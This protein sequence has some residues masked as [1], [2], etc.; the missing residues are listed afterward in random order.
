[1]TMQ[2]KI[3][4]LKNTKNG[5]VR[6]TILS[7]Q[8]TLHLDLKQ[9]L[10][11][12]DNAT[13]KTITEPLTGIE[14]WGLWIAAVGGLIGILAKNQNLSLEEIILLDKVQKKKELTKEEAKHLKSKNLIEGRRPNYFI[15][16]NV[17]QKTGQK[18]TYAKNK[19]FDKQYYLDLIVKSIKQHKSL[20]RSDIDDLLWKK[21][22]D[23]M[24][25]KQ[26]KSKIGNL[27]TELRKKEKIINKGIYSKPQWHLK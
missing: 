22:P 5:I 6:D 25:D 1:M 12:P 9:E 14:Y 4:I 13:V 21:L 16:K 17:A 10:F 20:T 27:I 8:D 15:G 3:I 23:Y 26:K 19:A 2:D 18:A 11:F 7:V 24:S